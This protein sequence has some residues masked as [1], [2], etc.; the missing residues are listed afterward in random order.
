MKRFDL[1]RIT[2]PLL[3]ATLLFC[4]TL[5]VTAFADISEEEARERF[6]EG[7]EYFD[8][9]DYLEAATIFEEVYEILGAVALLYNTGQAYYRA[10]RLADAERYFQAYLNEASSP[11]NEDEVVDLIIDIQEQRAA[12]EATVEITASPE[13]TEIFIDDEDEARCTTPCRFSIDPGD[14]Q[15]RAAAEG[16]QPHTEAISVE[17]RDSL[18]LDLTLSPEVRYGALRIHTSGASATAQINGQS[19]TLPSSEPIELTEGQHDIVITLDGEEIAQ[20]IDID[21]DQTAHLFIPSDHIGS[22]GFSTRQTAAIGLGGAASALSLAA[23]FVGAQARST[24]SDLEAQQQSLGGVDPSLRDAGQRQSS[25]SN[26][27]WLGA[28]T[29]LGA[30]AGLWTWDWLDSRST[31]DERLEPSPSPDSEDSDIDPA[32]PDADVDLL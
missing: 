32:D 5:P 14:Y 23:V 8:D 3:W 27:L 1:H 6:Q 10:D 15:L 17:A 12:R 28:F 7:R 20:T 4:L 31:S 25:L 30:G 24:H 21:A 13:D 11:P 16:H 22:G 2:S 26:G 29:A 18:D 19:H 9:G